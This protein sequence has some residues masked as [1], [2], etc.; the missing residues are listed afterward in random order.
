MKIPPAV[1]LLATTVCGVALLLFGGRPLQVKVT[2]E[3]QS[4]LVELALSLLQAEHNILVSGELPANR[5]VPHHQGM[6]R[7]LLTGAEWEQKLLAIR[8]GALESGIRYTQIDVTLSPRGV[9][10]HGDTVVLRA[11]DH[12]IE[13]I[14]Y[15]RPLLSGRSNNAQEKSDHDFV[16][17]VQPINA[18]SGGSYTVDVDGLRFTLVKDVTEPQMLKEEDEGEEPPASTLGEPLEQQS[19]PAKKSR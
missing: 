18:D 17:S 8:K 19:T 11:R 6:T 2:K 12:I 3:L 1:A 15:E 14:S 4:A 13:Y 9:E 5:L 7:T 16:F 10:Q